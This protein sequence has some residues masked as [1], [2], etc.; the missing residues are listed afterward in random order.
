MM[1]ILI[2][3]IISPQIHNVINQWWYLYNSVKDDAT[4][5]KGERVGRFLSKSLK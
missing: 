5:Y 1:D 3:S 2:N 4:I